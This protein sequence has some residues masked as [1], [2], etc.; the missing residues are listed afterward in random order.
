MMIGQNFLLKFQNKQNKKRFFGFSSLPLVF[1][2]LTSCARYG[3]DVVL[4]R[5]QLPF[6]PKVETKRT[7]E[8]VSLLGLTPDPLIP[9]MENKASHKIKISQNSQYKLVSHIGYQKGQISKSHRGS[10][11]LVTTEFTDNQ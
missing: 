2:F 1:L 7:F 9:T 11:L 4:E 5:P 10:F 3:E 8:G 6:S